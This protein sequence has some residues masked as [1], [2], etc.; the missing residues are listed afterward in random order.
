MDEINLE[1]TQEKINELT[2]NLATA[3]ISFL[4]FK[5]HGENEYLQQIAKEV[6]PTQFQ[7]IQAT[8][9]GKI[10]EILDQKEQEILSIGNGSIPAPKGI[11]NGPS[12]RIVAGFKLEAME[13]AK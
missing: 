2:Q 6:V 8:L 1:L 10:K 12:G 7:S 9:E 11:G 5:Y 4:L 13:K 3:C